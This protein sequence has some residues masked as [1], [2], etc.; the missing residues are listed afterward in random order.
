[1]SDI[2]DETIKPLKRLQKLSLFFFNRPRR[3]AI[4]CLAVVL[5]GVV[6]Y[7]TLLKKEGFPAIST[8]FA[9]SQGTY[10][11]NDPAKV[12]TEAAKPLS[13]FVM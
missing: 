5:F 3:T 12:D 7:T 6:S 1:M 2:K 8:P 4:L 9:L 11:V 13:E 10:L